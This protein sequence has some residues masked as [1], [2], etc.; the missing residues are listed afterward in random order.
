MPSGV[1]AS[2][3]Y[4]RLRHYDGDVLTQAAAGATGVFLCHQGSGHVCSGWLAH[5]PAEDLLAVRLALIDA[6]LHPDSLDYITSVPLWASGAEAADHGRRDL[7][8]P[9]PEALEVI[10]KVGRARGMTARAGH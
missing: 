10:A 5:R 7:E 6:R 8:V 1:W 4:D 2:E 3:E 9:G